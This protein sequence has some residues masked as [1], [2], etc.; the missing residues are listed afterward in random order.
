MHYIMQAKAAQ[1][2][3]GTEIPMHCEAS[4]A[5]HR[6]AQGLVLSNAVGLM[7]SDGM[8]DDANYQD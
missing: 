3:D 4:L 8:N 5:W 2:G 1:M 6:E 7:H